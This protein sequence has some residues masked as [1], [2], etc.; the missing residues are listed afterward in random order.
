MQ[1]SIIGKL[2]L[3]IT[4]LVAVSA[5]GQ[6]VADTTML[7]PIVVTATRIPVR[8]SLVTAQVTVLRGDDLAARGVDYLLEAL[9]EVVGVS[10]IQTG[11]FGGATSVFMRGGES[12]YVQVLVDGVPVNEPGGAY[13]FADLPLNN[14]DRVEIVH[15][16]AS[17]LYGS[18]AIAGVIQVF[19][20]TGNTPRAR[21]NVRGG[22]FGTVDVTADVSGGSSIGAYSF[23]VKNF[24][25]DGVYTRDSAGVPFNNDYRN[26]VAAGRFT[27][28]PDDQTDVGFSVRYADSKFSFPTDGSG[29]FVDQNSFTQSKVTTLGLDLVRRLGS[30]FETR[31]LLASNN[32][33]ATFDD[34][35]DGPADTLGFFEFRNLADVQRQ[36]GDVRLNYYLSQDNVLTAGFEIE[37][38]TQ[39]S[40]S[41]S[42]SQF[43][44]S[45]DS[46]D[47]DRDNRAY[48]AQA[49]FDLADRFSVSA[50]L[51]LDDNESFGT[52]VTYR[53][54][55]ALR[56]SQ[57]TRFR[58]SA[59]TGFKE[60]TFFE[61][62][63]TGFVL[64]NPELDPEKSLSWEVGI[65]QTA[66]G[67][68]V[69]FSGTYFRQDFEDLIQFTFASP[70]VGGPNYFNIAEARASGVEL[71]VT[72]VP[73]P[74]L[75]VAGNISLLDTEVTD[76]GFD[77]GDPEATFALGERLLRRPEVVFSMT[78]SYHVP[79]RGSATA[80]VH[81]VGDRIDRDFS[82]F[83]ASRVVLA[84]YTTVE[85]SGEAT[86]LRNDAGTPDVTATA[87][88][89]NLFDEDYQS[90]FGFP[91]RGRTIFLG[92]RLDI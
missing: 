8:R 2:L 21:A 5:Q 73:V 38:Q 65:E 41:E 53:G 56:L 70:T 10:V 82:S 62:F 15:G 75:T 49:I 44:P 22:T 40:F 4:L 52:F 61:N 71:Q 25:T 47:A 37:E 92:A 77:A 55:V 16:P 66:L 90:V 7:D 64:G 14:V 23:S 72:A 17:V 54:G 84:S 86:I 57:Q 31:I 19:T 51:R 39:R 60:P 36:S 24:S 26:T 27:L 48:Y 18:D 30:G 69:Q 58:V 79:G 13:N 59:G 68:R 67:G 20:K 81:H 6:Q 87:R 76:A 11:S 35:Q 83:P 33:D 9:K 28:R 29:A 88:V 85:L 63:A 89:E 46:F 32:I 43:G 1:V 80:G 45:S 91:A 78:A 74:Q 50:G 12:D 34:S 42:N 3:V